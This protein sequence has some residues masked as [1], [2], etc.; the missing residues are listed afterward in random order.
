MQQSPKIF[1]WKWP[2][3]FIVV[4]AELYTMYRFML[5]YNSLILLALILGS[6]VLGIIL[7]RW[8]GSICWKRIL[9]MERHNISSTDEMRDGVLIIFAGILMIIPGLITD[10]IGLFL[11]LPPIRWVVRKLFLQNL[12]FEI[13]AGMESQLRMHM[14][15]TATSE[16]DSQNNSNYNS[17]D[18]SQDGCSETRERHFNQNSDVQ[19]IDITATEP[20]RS[21]AS[22]SENREGGK[23]PDKRQD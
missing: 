13:P 1:G 6:I 22:E 23:L 15:T 7:M 10:I 19:I 11:F 12:F 14:F 16:D 9:Y 8:E 17:E 2:V 5:A 21:A 4:A 3:F 18:I 20:N